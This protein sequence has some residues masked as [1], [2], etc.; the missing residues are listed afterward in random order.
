MHMP[1]PTIDEVRELTVRIG[2]ALRDLGIDHEA[3]I[4]QLVDAGDDIMVD[5]SAVTFVDIA[6]IEL[7]A[8]VLGRA[9]ARNRTVVLR[10]ASWELRR[11]LVLA[12][13]EPLFRYDDAS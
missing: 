6:G 1:G 3:D 9:C 12:G 2:D 11:L 4:D 8:E 5:V 13:V 10:G 7:L